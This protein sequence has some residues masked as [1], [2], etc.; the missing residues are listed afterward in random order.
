MKIEE[1][2]IG[3]SE[4]ITSTMKAVIRTHT[5]PVINKQKCRETVFHDKEIERSKH[6]RGNVCK[7]ILR[8]Y[9][10]I[11]LHGYYPN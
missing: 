6:I 8:C 5:V 1:L 4:K 2:Y 11:I 9:L 3:E 10:F 7:C